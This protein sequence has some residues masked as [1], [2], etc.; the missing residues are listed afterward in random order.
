[1][2]VRGASAALA[3]T[4]AIG[5]AFSAGCGDDDDF[6][7]AFFAGDV[8]SVSGGSASNRRTR[9]TFASR[10]FSPPLA[11]AQSS[12]AAPSG[13]LLFCVDEHCTHVDADDCHFARVVRIA[14]GG[15]TRVVLRFVDDADE[16]GDADDTESNSIVDQDLEVCSGDQI[17]IG[18]AAVDF[19]G[20]TTADV[21]KRVDNC[22][23]GV[24][25]R[26]N[27]P[28]GATPTRTVTPGGATPT[29]TPTYGMT[30]NDAPGPMLVFF[31]SLGLIGLLIPR[32]RQKGSSPTRTASP[33]PG[34]H[35]R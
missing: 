8:S 20:S 9:Q 1:M 27:T 13:D 17:R 31:A 3:V 22:A 35:G 19:D 25:I 2:R 6:E 29:R 28:G 4:L 7:G 26:T 18:D 15:P 24:P 30:M 11:W 32:R 23:D 14:G 16:D 21:S 10:W 33:T 12:C 34:G 5:G